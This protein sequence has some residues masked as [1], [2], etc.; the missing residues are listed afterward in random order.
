M[1]ALSL[2]KNNVPVRIIE[3]DDHFHSME[4]GSGIM[5]HLPSS[6][7]FASFLIHLKPRTLEI[8]HLLGV[9]S[10]IKRIGL[11]TPTLHFFEP[12]NP[13]KPS[14]SVSMVERFDPTPS[15]P[16]VSLLILC[17]YYSTKAVI[18]RPAESC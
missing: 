11:P 6:S 18:P 12:N 3:K 7:L 10:D 8:E 15:F 9:E 1:L 14:R 17:F 4:R 13:R 2:L 16:T 5:V